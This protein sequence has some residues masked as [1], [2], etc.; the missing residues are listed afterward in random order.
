MKSIGVPLL[1]N[2]SLPEDEATVLQKILASY[3][4]T[5]YLRVGDQVLDLAVQQDV[6][7]LRNADG[8]MVQI[9]AD[10]GADAGE[11]LTAVHSELVKRKCCY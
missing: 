8:Q 7:Q 11:L 4:S 10:G 6:D 2:P 9:V 5:A 3:Q 1:V